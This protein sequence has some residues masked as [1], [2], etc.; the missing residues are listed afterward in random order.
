MTNDISIRF[1]KIRYVIFKIKSL[2]L[3][4]VNVKNWRD[5]L[6]AQAGPI[7]LEIRLS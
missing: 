4:E 1:I 5:A 6:A 3:R 2:K 7:G